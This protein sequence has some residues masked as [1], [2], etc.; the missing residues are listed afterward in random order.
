MK[1]LKGIIDLIKVASFTILPFIVYS[2]LLKILE[3]IISGEMFVRMMIIASIIFAIILKIK[4]N[5]GE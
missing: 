1:L 3:N 4:I 2:L 5:K